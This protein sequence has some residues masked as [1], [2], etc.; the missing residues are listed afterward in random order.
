MG[1]LRVG[2]LALSLRL[3]QGAGD[4]AGAL[5]RSVEQ[6]FLPAVLDALARDLDDR[7]GD[8]AVI[9][10]RT[11]RIKLRI[12]PET[13]NAADLAR[14]VGQ[15]LAAHVRDTAFIVQP[16]QP[17]MGAAAEVRIWPTEGAWHG[18]A[19]I[20]ALR[21][22]AGPA[23]QVEDPVRV[24]DAVMTAGAEAVATAL[25]HC[26]EA[27]LL[28]DL[29]AVLPVP[30]VRA[31]LARTASLLP[32]MLRSSLAEAVTPPPAGGPVSAEPTS[33]PVSPRRATGKTPG[34]ANIPGQAAADA[35]A[36]QADRPAPAAR[37]QPL[38]KAPAGKVGRPGTVIPRVTAFEEANVP[39]DHHRAAA[40]PHI[41]LQ[42]PTPRR[43]TRSRDDPAPPV[44]GASP[45]DQDQRGVWVT[46]WGGLAYLITLAMRLGMPEALWRIGVPEGAALS[47][48]LATLSKAK[49]DPLLAAIVPDAPLVPAFASIP[50]W[51]G[52]EFRAAMTAA[53]ED[54]AGPDLFPAIPD[55]GD[56]DLIEWGAALLLATMQRLIG[57]SGD[58]DF[59]SDIL[60]VT[61]TVEIDP[62][63]ICLRLPLSAINLDIRSAGLDANPGALAWMDKRLVIAFGSGEEDWSG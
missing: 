37:P 5:Q 60:A 18:S 53:A 21:G 63:L 52:Q 50:D 19:L 25:T 10:V 45:P 34:A 47:A 26:A 9:Q 58:D 15:D 17:D 44:T 42:V 32:V 6:R 35:H 22:Q 29:L 41:G 55:G 40:D 56:F 30:T 38:G 28:P 24:V 33:G 39:A 20:A 46:S 36:S 23:G 3:P 27:G 31:L 4:R 61:G 2:S 7:F 57:R 11:L 59:P 49:D 43:V 48:M 62:G 14:Q 13:R 51:A 1:S 8:T 54:L 12:G 16:G